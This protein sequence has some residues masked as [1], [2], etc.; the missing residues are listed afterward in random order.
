VPTHPSASI[1]QGRCPSCGGPVDIVDRAKCPQCESIVNSGKYDWV[2]AE[3]TQD[4][5]WVVP[6]VNAHFEDFW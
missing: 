3:I 1:L 2:L 5:E 4:E 6:T